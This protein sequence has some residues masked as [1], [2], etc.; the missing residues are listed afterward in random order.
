MLFVFLVHAVRL[1][2]LKPASMT[3]VLLILKGLL[4]KITSMSVDEINVILV[5]VVINCLKPLMMK[6]SFIC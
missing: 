5:V 1:W 2:S 3:V 6:R 4:I